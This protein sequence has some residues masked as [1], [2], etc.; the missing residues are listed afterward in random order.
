MMAI[1]RK[2]ELELT[3]TATTKEV[4][5]RSQLLLRKRL[6]ILGPSA[7]GSAKDT[8]YVKITE[9]A[10]ESVCERLKSARQAV[11]AIEIGTGEVACK[12]MHSMRML[13]MKGGT[14]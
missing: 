5:E 2:R 11:T 7:T 1:A 10:H 9:H 12:V 3:V 4:L 8:R 13:G 6:L 14:S